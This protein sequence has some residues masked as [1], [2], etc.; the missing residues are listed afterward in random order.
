MNTNEKVKQKSEHLEQVEFVSWFRKNY[1]P[2][3][4]V[5]AIP[6]GG[7]RSKGVAMSLKAEG[8]TAGVPDLMIPSLGVFIEMK[9]EK[10]G[11]VSPE[12]MEWLDYLTSVG[13]YTKVCNGCEEAKQFVL[14]IIK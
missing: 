3:H 13:Y 4:R 6:H 9:K 5:F 11:K 14:S 1:H 12:Q 8:A 7:L 2:T 10:G